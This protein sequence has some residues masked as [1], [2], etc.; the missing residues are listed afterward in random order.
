ML[1]PEE[2]KR[3]IDAARTLRGL[4]QVDLAELLEADGHGKHD[5]GRLERG[6]IPFSA[7]LRRSL[8]HHLEVPEAWFV[9]EHVDGIIINAPAATAGEPE[10]DRADLSRRLSLIESKLAARTDHDQLVRDMLA[11]QTEILTKIEGLVSGFPSDDRMDELARLL[12]GDGQ[13]GQPEQLEPEESDAATS[14]RPAEA[15]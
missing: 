1:T 13:P 4:R 11:R 3:R 12:R 8:A 14:S 6:E 2:L 15:G 9:D 7:A 10:P 5:V